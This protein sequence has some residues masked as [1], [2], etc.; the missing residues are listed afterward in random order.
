MNKNTYQSMT[1]FETFIVS[2]WLNND[3]VHLP[4]LTQLAQSS[5]EDKVQTLK[6]YVENEIDKTLLP[7]MQTHILHSAWFILDLVSHCVESEVN[8]LEILSTAKEV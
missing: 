5:Q 6:T 2:L 8:Y 1:N 4:Y 3:T 7:S